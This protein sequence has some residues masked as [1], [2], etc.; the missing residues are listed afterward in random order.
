ML[1]EEVLAASLGIREGLVASE[2]IQNEHGVD[3]QHL[4]M[5]QEAKQESWVVCGCRS[6]E[7][8]QFG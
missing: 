6:K 5:H 8:Y 1:H 7:A 3:Q 2:E 4:L